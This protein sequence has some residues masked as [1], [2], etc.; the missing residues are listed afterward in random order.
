MVLTESFAHAFARGIPVAPRTWRLRGGRRPAAC[1][2]GRGCERKPSGASGTSL[3]WCIVLWPLRSTACEYQQ[4]RCAP[5]FSLVEAVRTMF[6]P[7]AARVRRVRLRNMRR[8]LV[9]VLHV[10]KTDTPA[11]RDDLRG[12][13]AIEH[14]P[15]RRPERVCGRSK[16]SA[17][18]S[19]TTQ[20]GTSALHAPR[21]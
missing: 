21:D 4:V 19:A 5:E 12:A 3:T 10:S 7:H 20:V 18:T 14:A 15:R 11:T 6:V 8:P 16:K 13:Y 17:E 2:R 9:S 1:T